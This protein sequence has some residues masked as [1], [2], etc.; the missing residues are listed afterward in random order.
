MFSSLRS[1]GCA[2]WAASIW[3]AVRHIT[4]AAVRLEAANLCWAWAAACGGCALTLFDCKA[5][6]VVGDHHM[7]VL[8]NLMI[9][10]PAISAARLINLELEGCWALVLATFNL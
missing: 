9:R 6:G 5:C 3:C 4:L 8:W 2:H 1:A 10:R 7:T